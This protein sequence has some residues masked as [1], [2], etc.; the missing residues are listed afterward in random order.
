MTSGYFYTIAKKSLWKW[1]SLNKLQVNFRMSTAHTQSWDIHYDAMNS[2][3]P[4]NIVKAT[5]A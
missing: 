4:E 5:F 1:A 3:I 2:L